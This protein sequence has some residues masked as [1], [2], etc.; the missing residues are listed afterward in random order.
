MSHKVNKVLR[1][2]VTA[3]SI[4]EQLEVKT[5]Y[6]WTLKV[7]PEDAAALLMVKTG[8]SDVAFSI[9]YQTDLALNLFVFTVEMYAYGDEGTDDWQGEWAYDTLEQCFQKV[10][11][12]IEEVCETC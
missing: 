7:D 6:G 5:K 3:A 10:A 11:Q 4:L 12:E 8:K 2:A 1:V 9:Y